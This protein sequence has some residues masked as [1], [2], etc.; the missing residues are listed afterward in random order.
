[1]EINQPGY[2]PVQP[3]YVTAPQPIDIPPAQPTYTPNYPPS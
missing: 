1:M 3:A 2:D